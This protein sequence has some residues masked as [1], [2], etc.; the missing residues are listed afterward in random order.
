MQAVC[1]R[2]ANARAYLCFLESVCTRDSAAEDGR[3][4]DGCTTAAADCGVAEQCA[5][6]AMRELAV[7]RSPPLPG[8]TCSIRGFTLAETL[9]G[10]CSVYGFRVSA[11]GRHS[12]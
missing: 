4:A 1:S 10:S 5:A 2:A 6:E 12:V 11:G 3:W 8:E 9:T 7:C